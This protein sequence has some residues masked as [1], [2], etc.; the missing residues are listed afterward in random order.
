MRTDLSANS[1]EQKKHRR[2]SPKNFALILRD[3]QRARVEKRRRATIARARA[4]V[5][6]SVWTRGSRGYANMRRVR[7]AA[8]AAARA[9]YARVRARAVAASKA[10]KQQRSPRG[11]SRFFASIH[12]TPTWRVRR[13]HRF[14]EQTSARSGGRARA[15]LSPDCV[16]EFGAA[17]AVQSLSARENAMRSGAREFDHYSNFRKKQSR[18]RRAII[19][20]RRRLQRL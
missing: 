17:R 4:R 16:D 5:A 11:S 9:C 7:N 15:R 3:R 8:V 1:I 14:V 10:R 12:A 18:C 2:N 13:L 6:G 19:R 20:L